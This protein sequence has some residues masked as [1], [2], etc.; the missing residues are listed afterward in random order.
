VYEFPFYREQEGLAG[1]VLGGWQ[2]NAFFT[3]QSGTPFTILNGADAIFGS[4]STPGF[5]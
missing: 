3:L 1:H 2:A 4:A 5:A